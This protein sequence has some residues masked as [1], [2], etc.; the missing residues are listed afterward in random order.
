M[1]LSLFFYVNCSRKYLHNTFN[2]YM[3]LTY[4]V[5]VHRSILLHSFQ[6]VCSMKTNGTVHSL[7]IFL[8][9][10]TTYCSKVAFPLEVVQKDNCFNSPMKLPVH[11]LYLEYGVQKISCP[12]IDGFFPSNIK[13][14]ITWYMVSKP[15]VIY[16]L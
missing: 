4:K 14:N 2:C 6:C 10:N 13:P 11:K 9:R 12:N 7:H 8:F 16:P 3:N 1:C 15:E 5:S